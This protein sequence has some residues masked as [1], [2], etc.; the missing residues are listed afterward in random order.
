MGSRTHTLEPPL[1]N[2]VCG[3]VLGSFQSRPLRNLVR[4]YNRTSQHP[5]WM[6]FRPGTQVS[7]VISKIIRSL[8]RSVLKAS[9]NCGADVQNNYDASMYRH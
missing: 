9:F 8:Q 1:Q 4:P 6:A 5:G 2:P 7:P 3:P